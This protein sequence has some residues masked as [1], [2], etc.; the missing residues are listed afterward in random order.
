MGIQNFDF[1]RNSHSEGVDYSVRDGLL[2][3][4]S[5]LWNDIAKQHQN[6]SVTDICVLIP[7][8]VKSKDKHN[9]PILTIPKNGVVMTP[10]G[11]QIA[12]ILVKTELVN[13]KII[14]YSINSYQVGHE[15]ANN[16]LS[17]AVYA[18]FNNPEKAE[19]QLRKVIDEIEAVLM[20]PIRSILDANNSFIG[21][22]AY[23]FREEIL[24]RRE[25]EELLL[26]VE[27]FKF[28]KGHFWK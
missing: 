26:F 18:H 6:D 3:L 12:E 1:L 8:Y 2:G 22:S 20:N 25:L 23:N 7:Y 11:E 10:L 24:S 4:N 27:G 5:P 19:E 13:C 9:N 14:Q 28:T 21:M 17:L 16:R 15:S